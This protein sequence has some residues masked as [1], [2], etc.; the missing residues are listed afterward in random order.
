[1]RLKDPLTP[2]EAGQAA[3]SWTDMDVTRSKSQPPEHG[4]GWGVGGG[5]DSS[6]PQGLSHVSVLGKHIGK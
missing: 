3:G 4:T 2:S 5:S 1:M 6:C